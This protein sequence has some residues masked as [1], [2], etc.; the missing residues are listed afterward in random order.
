MYSIVI[1]SSETTLTRRSGYRA[2]PGQ[3]P[4]IHRLYRPTE[5]TTALYSYAR[6]LHNDAERMVRFSIEIFYHRAG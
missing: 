2:G 1:V 4:R 3:V 5:L 6:E